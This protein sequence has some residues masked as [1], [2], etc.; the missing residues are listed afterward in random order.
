ML[1]AMLNKKRIEASQMTDKDLE[2]VCPFCKEKMIL[3]KPYEK[4]VDH[5][6]H[7]NRC[8]FETEPETREHVNGKKILYDLFSSCKN[9]RSCE[10]EPKL[11]FGRFPDL[12]LNKKVAVEFQ[13]ST[14][15]LREFMERTEEYTRNKIYILWIF[16]TK[17]F[18]R[19][20]EDKDA[21]KVRFVEKK[22]HMIYYGHVFYLDNETEE[23]LAVSF[24]SYY[25]D[26]Y[27]EWTGND[28]RK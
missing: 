23:L 2:Y 18:F 9:I 22:A 20:H 17:H 27:N 15:S 5:F 26:R 12:L 10:I 19:S 3:V 16:G 1:S 11:A 13:C 7:Y 21:V 8:E 25:E 24:S 14:I 28:Y 6:R 4:I